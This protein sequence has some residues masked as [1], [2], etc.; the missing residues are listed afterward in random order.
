VAGGAAEFLSPI[1]QGEVAS[2]NPVV[3]SKERVRSN[4]VPAAPSRCLTGLVVVRVAR[5][6]RHR[7]G[8]GQA[9]LDHAHGP[10]HSSR[11]P[12]RA[13]WVSCSCNCRSRRGRPHDSGGVARSVVHPATAEL[14]ADEGPHPRFSR[15]RSSKTS[16]PRSSARPDRCCLVA[17]GTGREAP[18]PRP[19]AAEGSRPARR[20]GPA[21]RGRGPPRS[22]GQNPKIPR[23]QTGL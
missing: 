6:C 2:S 16:W 5:P 8:H 9:P 10:G 12:A 14:V 21:F 1:C 4:G 23:N 22:V 3:R 20:S 7:P 11:C 13:C 19:R 17:I 15:S 18:R